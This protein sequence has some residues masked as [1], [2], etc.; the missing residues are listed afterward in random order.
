VSTRQLVESFSKSSLLGAYCSDEYSEECMLRKNIARTTEEFPSCLDMGPRDCRDSPLCQWNAQGDN[1]CGIDEEQAVLRIV[2]PQ[3]RGHPLVETIMMHDHCSKQTHET[4]DAEDACLMAYSMGGRRCDVKPS[5]IVREMLEYPKLMIDTKLAQAEATCRAHQLETHGFKAKCT[6]ICRMI[7]GVCRMDPREIERAPIPPLGAM[8]D[9]MCNQAFHAEHKCPAPCEE[10]YQHGHQPCRGPERYHSR[11]F[12]LRADQH[13]RA[14]DHIVKV[15][16]VLMSSTMLYQHRC[17]DLGHYG[18][19]MCHAASQVCDVE[20][21]DFAKH[22]GPH[23]ADFA[24]NRTA[25]AGSPGFKGIFKRATQAIAEGRAEHFLEDY[26]ENNPEAL[27]NMTKKAVDMFANFFK[28]SNTEAKEPAIV[29]PE[30]SP[31]LEPSPSHMVN[32]GPAEPHPRR[33]GRA[34]PIL[35]GLGGVI[36]A[37]VCAG[38]ACGALCHARILGTSARQ[39]L[40]LSAPQGA[41]AAALDQELGT[42]GQSY[43]PAAPPVPAANEAPEAAHDAE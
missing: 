6:G 7:D 22:H 17:D 29:A 39:P 9:M 11:S 3:F 37:T 32:E 18:S 26:F 23:F 1:A 4:C 5:W 15:F 43:T 40:L 25:M 16:T 41:G 38:V 36:I 20:K 14:S 34:A 2:G 31:V 10:H 21:H 12:T 27:G 24:K 8:L 35:V 13:D 28:S 30:P 33:L 19:N 42:R